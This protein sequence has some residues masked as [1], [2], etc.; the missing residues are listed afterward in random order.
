MPELYTNPEME[1]I[2]VLLLL[3]HEILKS[4]GLFIGLYGICLHIVYYQ[5]RDDFLAILL[6]C[7]LHKHSPV[8]L[9]DEKLLFTFYFMKIV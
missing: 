8:S 9:E 4:S 6:I 7:N 1:Q 2:V 5:I 3:G